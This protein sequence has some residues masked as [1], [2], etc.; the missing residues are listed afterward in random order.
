MAFTEH[1]R[2]LARV[3]GVLYLIITAC[4]LFA[5]MHVRG[6]LLDTDDMAQ[7]VANLAA[8]E[9]LYRWGFAA[10]VIVVVCNLPMGV[11]LFELLKKVNPRVALLALVFIISSATLEGVNLLN[12]IEPLF[13]VT[14]PEYTRA[15]DADEIQALV[16]GSMRMFAYTFSV[17]LVFFGAYCV[18]IGF[19]IFRST[20]FPR[21]LGVLMMVAGV[22]Y[23]LNSLRLFLSLPI[24]YIEW[25]TLVGEL[26]L[27]LWLVA[28]GVNEAK[29]RAL[30]V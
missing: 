28:V 5:Y 21:V 23:W 4:A 13:T 2:V 7:T 16:R 11:I 25:V 15:F 12:Y 24:P 30:K 18:L 10:A 20:F 3:A 27:A 22:T 17:S 8:R 19:L 29:W 6:E 1:P 14:L 9:Q 26:A